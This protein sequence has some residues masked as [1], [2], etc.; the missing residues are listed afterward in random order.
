MFKRKI[1]WLSGAAIATCC[2]LGIYLLSDQNHS[3]SSLEAPESE[4]ETIA[5]TKSSRNGSSPEGSGEEA[6]VRKAVVVPEELRDQVQALADLPEDHTDRGNLIMEI[7]TA[8]AKINPTE[9]LLW[10]DSLDLPEG[11]LASRSI[12]TVMRKDTSPAEAFETV[13]SL[14]G[15]SSELR[16]NGQ[17]LTLDSW[18]QT[19]FTSAWDSAARSGMDQDHLGEVRKVTGQTN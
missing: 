6:L 17:L 3:V 18:A 11:L 8:W 19:D 7:A 9:A 14:Q 12:I 10:A 5:N 1:A 15:I 13:S 4:Q 2:L 16:A